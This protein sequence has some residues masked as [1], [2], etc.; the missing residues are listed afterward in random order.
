M[1]IKL[2]GFEK[3]LT[4]KII[5]AILYIIKFNTKFK[6]NTMR[7]LIELRI[8]NYLVIIGFVHTISIVILNGGSLNL[9]SEVIA[10]GLIVMYIFWLKNIHKRIDKHIQS[11]NQ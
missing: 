3:Y 1:R 2:R 6:I 7:K 9:Q 5:D 8:E 4:N 11:L 10:L